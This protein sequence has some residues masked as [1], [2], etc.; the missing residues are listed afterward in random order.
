MTSSV[1]GEKS[2]EGRTLQTSDRRDYGAQNYNYVPKSP[3]WRTFG[4]VH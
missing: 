3:D 4:S 2:G 1:A